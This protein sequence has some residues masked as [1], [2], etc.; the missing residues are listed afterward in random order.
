MT[1]H[2]TGHM[3]SPLPTLP[4]QLKRKR[5]LEYG[6]EKDE[7]WNGMKRMKQ[8]GG[9]VDTC[10]RN[11][12]HVL[13]WEEPCKTDSRDRN[14]TDQFGIVWEGIAAISGGKDLDPGGQLMNCDAKQPENGPHGFI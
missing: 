12:G 9:T 3:T 13:H 5:G 6:D 7:A 8:T 10:T 14:K 2:M 1:S 11:S 4:G